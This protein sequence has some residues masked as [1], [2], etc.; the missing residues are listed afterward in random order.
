MSSL[1]PLTAFPALARPVNRRRFLQRCGR[2]AAAASATLAGGLGL[3]L[4]NV[5]AEDTVRANHGQPLP[6]PPLKLG[7]RA[8]TMRMAGDLNV[9]QTVA[10]M[11]NIRGVEL[12]MNSAGRNL[13]DLATVRQYKIA[14]DR[15]AV[16]IPSIAGI[17]DKGVNLF[18]SKAGETLRESIRI[19]ELLGSRVVLVAFFKEN[20]PDLEREESYGPVVATLQKAALAAEAA[21][22]IL[23]LENSLPP[24]GNVKLVDLV[25]HAAVKVYYDI[26]N[27]STYGHAAE[28][29]PGI[30]L[31]GKD[32]ICAV[33]VKNGDRLIEAP[34]PIDWRGAF[35][36]F[37]EIGYEGWFTYETSHK[38]LEACLSDTVWNNTFLI[39]NL[40]P[41]TQEKQ[42]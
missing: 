35:Q 30:K 25:G 14:S 28:A 18:S 36:A 1:R 19:A 5:S 29:V 4:A 26:F 24:S 38:N 22:V 39:K 41:E 17:W 33:H 11:P 23:G 12:Q 13:R 7:I 8:A 21:G 42:A 37:N 31:M 40:R 32:R 16:R 27:M 20:A 2:S 34:G 15:W 10:T 3:G 6:R 9:I